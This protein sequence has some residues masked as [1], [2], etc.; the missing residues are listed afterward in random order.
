MNNGFFISS[1][2]DGTFKIFNSLTGQCILSMSEPYGDQICQILKINP[3][4]EDNNLDKT[5]ILLLSRHLIF[6]RLN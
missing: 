2:L 4:K 3:I 5:Y 1:S 6:I